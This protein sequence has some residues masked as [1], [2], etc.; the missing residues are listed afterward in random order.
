MFT[1]NKESEVPL[2]QQLVYSLK[3]AIKDGILK[4][5]DKIPAES[6]FCSKYDLSR[7][8]VRQAL[9]ILER[10]G[11]IYKIR[12]KGSYISSP[13]IYQNRSGFSK[14]YDDMRSLGKIPV[15]KILSIKVKKPNELVREKMN[16]LENELVFKLVWV[17]YGNDEALIY[18]TIYLNYLLVQG[19]ENINLKNR[20]LYEVLSEEFGVKITHGE[21]MFY[22]C[23]LDTTEA[24][25]LELT[26]GDLGMRVERTTFQGEKILE[27]T[28][29]TVRGDKFVYMTNFSGNNYY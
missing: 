11:Y 14:F 12:G 8:T 5:N 22:P 3:K 4:K 18:E 13:K 17:R 6:E 15:S 10:E 16:L 7:T 24:K 2:Y 9:E 29:S 23:K 20:K 28:Q 25:Y 19:I 21:E 27:Y 1:I 26:E